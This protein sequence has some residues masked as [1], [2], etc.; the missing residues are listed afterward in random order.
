VGRFFAGA[1]GKMAP[2]RSGHRTR[3]VHA[4]IYEYMAWRPSLKIDSSDSI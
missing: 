2:E 1:P 3:V 4:A